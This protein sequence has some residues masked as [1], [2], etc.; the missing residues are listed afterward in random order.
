M[1][2]EKVFINL[3]RENC[4]YLYL[5]SISLDSFHTPAKN[6]EESV[7]YERRKFV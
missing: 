2:L 5:S 3:L 7:T 4:E 1:L 6:A